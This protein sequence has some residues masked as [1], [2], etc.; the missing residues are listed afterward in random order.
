MVVEEMAAAYTTAVRKKDAE[1]FAA[2]YAD[3][4]R[5]FDMW[6]NFSLEG[7]GAVRRMADGWFASVGTDRIVVEFQEVRETT[8]AT[9]RWHTRS[10]GSAPSRPRAR[11]CAR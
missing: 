1:A 9:S 7:A 2:L 5:N 8:A 3:D 10:S 11:S 4:A 6:G